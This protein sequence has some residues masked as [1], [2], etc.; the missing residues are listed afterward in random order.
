[1]PRTRIN[2]IVI[3]AAYCTVG[4][5]ILCRNHCGQ[6]TLKCQLQKLEATSGSLSGLKLAVI[7]PVH[8][9]DRALAMESLKQWPSKCYPLTK[10]NVDLVIYQ[11]ESMANKV[12]VSASVINAPSRCFRM[13][14]VVSGNLRPEVSNKFFRLVMEKSWLNMEGVHHYEMILEN[15]FSR[16]LCG[17]FDY[18]A[19]WCNFST[20]CNDSIHA[21]FPRKIRN[22]LCHSPQILMRIKQKFS[23]AIGNI[24]N[25]LRG[26]GLTRTRDRKMK[27]TTKS[28]FC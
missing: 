21:N 14:R 8:R 12:D 7:V 17:G 23:L 18:L 13:A 2:V 15:N 1:M 11:A 25:D 5:I 22:V 3:I 24:S 6:D 28:V 9:G 16:L 20:Y 27:N 19:S 10:Q 4:W 26:G